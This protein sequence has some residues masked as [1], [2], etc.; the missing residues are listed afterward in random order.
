MAQAIPLPK[1]LDLPDL[2]IF[3]RE[4]PSEPVLTM[5]VPTNEDRTEFETY[6]VKL[7]QGE[8]Q[9]WMERLPHYRALMDKLGYEMHVAFCPRTG[10]FHAMAD[11]DELNYTQLAIGCARQAAQ[12]NPLTSAVEK[13][14]RLERSAPAPISQLRSFLAGPERHYGARGGF[15]R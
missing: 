12:A 4:H 13:R 5:Q 14:R 9:A 10:H 8:H 7:E 1:H 11:L 6:L 15:G 3:H 2:V